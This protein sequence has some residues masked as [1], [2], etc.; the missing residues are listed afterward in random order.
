MDELSTKVEE[1]ENN[2]AITEARI[3]QLSKIMVKQ[4]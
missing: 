2:H 3:E 1:G 4:S